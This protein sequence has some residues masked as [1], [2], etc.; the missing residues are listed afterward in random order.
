LLF[1]FCCVFIFFISFL[2]PVSC[3][4]V[5]GIDVFALGATVY[6]MVVGRP[7]WM[8][9]NQIDLATKIKNFEL[10]FPTEGVDPHLKHLLR[11]MLAKDYRTRCDLDAIVVDDWVTFEGSQPLFEKDEYLCHDFIDYPSFQANEDPFS[12]P[13]HILIIHSSLVIRTMLHHQINNNIQPAMS[14]VAA[15]PEEALDIMKN[16]MSTHPTGN[17]EYIFFELSSTNRP[18]AYDA[19]KEIRRLGKSLSWCLLPRSLHLSVSFLSFLSCFRF[20]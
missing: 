10:T 3:L 4:S 5:I 7:P 17:F 20:H 13:L 11:Q 18:V 1:V 19:I 16:V 9:R 2:L 14:V 6:Y 15:N 8:A 12:T